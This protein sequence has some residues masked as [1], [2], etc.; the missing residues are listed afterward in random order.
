MLPKSFWDFGTILHNCKEF[1]CYSITEHFIDNINCNLPT[2]SRFFLLFGLRNGSSQDSDVSALNGDGRLFHR[3]VKENATL[4]TNT[5][6]RLG[7]HLSNTDK[8]ALTPRHTLKTVIKTPRVS[9]SLGIA[10][11]ERTTQTA[12]GKNTLL[13]GWCEFSRPCFC[14]IVITTCQPWTPN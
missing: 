7:F 14:V 5:E 8:A 1:S 3:E 4:N 11:H 12:D 2:F 9:D 10:A 6:L 13:C